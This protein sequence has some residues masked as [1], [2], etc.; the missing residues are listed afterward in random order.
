MDELER[1]RDYYRQLSRELGAKVL[2]LEQFATRAKHETARARTTTRLI[3]RLYR[4]SGSDAGGEGF[5]PRFLRFIID[6][7]NVDGAALLLR[8]LDEDTW[9]IRHA[10]GFRKEFAQDLVLPGSSEEYFVVNSTSLC[11]PGPE[12]SRQTFGMPFVLWTYNRNSGFALLLGSTREDR[13]LR[14]KFKEEDREIVEGVMG[15]FADILARHKAE[16][17][18]RIAKEA[19]ESANAAKSQFLA[20]MS[21]EI[22]TPMNGVVG[23]LELLSETR[24]DD[25]QRYFKE[26]AV[27]SANTLL[28]VINDILD[29]SKIEAR[30]LDLEQVDFNLENI[31]DE[32]MRMFSRTAGEKRLGLA[33]IVRDR[34]PHWLRGDQNRLKQVLLNLISNA[35]KFTQAGAVIVNADL[36]DDRGAQVV[37]RVT[38]RDSGVGI[39]PAVQAHLFDPF[40]Q[41][42]ASTTRKFGGTG[43]GL[44]ISN[45]LVSLMG[46]EI[47]VKNPAVES[48]PPHSGPGSEFWFTAVLDKAVFTEAT[49]VPVL[50]DLDGMRI[51]I[52]EGNQLVGESLCELSHSLGGEA[53]STENLGGALSLLR[54]AAV[55]HRP[56]SVALV[57]DLI[58]APER[59]AL[60]RHIRGDPRT[61]GIRLI[62]LTSSMD[63]GCGSQSIAGDSTSLPKPVS[64][65]LLAKALSPPSHDDISREAVPG[66]SAL[67]PDSGQPVVRILIAEDNPVNQ[68]IMSAML[69]LGGYS[70]DCVYNG[71]EAID[72]IARDS[73]DLVLMDCQMP[74]MDGFEA[75]RIIRAKEAS[76]HDCQ[77]QVKNGNGCRTK[78]PIIALTAHAMRGYREQCLAAGMDD[79][80]AK[81][82][83]TEELLSILGKWL[84]GNKK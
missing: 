65:T 67:V 20:N 29:F 48:L 81:P 76:T 16:Q 11:S 15:A 74:E 75:T 46:G 33:Y 70:C 23:S 5:E 32:T 14:P 72:A 80:L 1:E 13:H 82:C 60:A 49:F 39:T 45:Q 66:T 3:S 9:T 40:S 62:T 69:E 8:L 21:H 22:R 83:R 73:Y 68:E 77:Q 61:A 7:M 6:A 26:M 35:M 25:R 51:L 79:Y 47:G 27:S 24:L 78:I 38:V 41:G 55:D 17:A 18:L 12:H 19:A 37:V 4:I 2:H 42:D 10:V 28:T 36:E 84:S 30:R 57:D 50:P 54:Q 44:A 64:R 31:I 63:R 43:L 71:T 58:A 56:F 53:V 59:E 52:L 34:I